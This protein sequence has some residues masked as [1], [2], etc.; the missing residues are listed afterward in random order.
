MILLALGL[1]RR[2]TG[3]RGKAAAAALGRLPVSPRVLHER[4]KLQLS[5]NLGLV[6][7]VAAQETS[8]RLGILCAVKAS[9]PVQPAVDVSVKVS[10]PA[11]SLNSL[12]VGS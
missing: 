4:V 12:Q 6:C 2:V 8:E 5:D 1:V 3:R 9:M 7:E 11:P 10:N